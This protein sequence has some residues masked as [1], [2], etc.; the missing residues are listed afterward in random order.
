MLYLTYNTREDGMGAQFQRIVGIIAIAKKFDV[1]YV[2]TPIKQME[3]V[4]GKKYIKKIENYFLIKNHY[5]HVNDRSYDKTFE[6]NDVRVENIEQFK[7]MAEDENINILYKIGLPRKIVDSEPEIHSLVLPEL[8]NIKRT[9]PLIHYKQHDGPNIAIHIRRGDV[10]MAKYP[11]RF[12]PVEFYL[13]LMK[14]MRINMPSPHFH[15]FTEITKENE[16]EFDILNGE[17]VTI[18][19]NLDILETIEHLIMADVLVT[20]KSSFSYLAALYNK[21]MVIYFDFWHS[22]MP[23]WNRIV[24]SNT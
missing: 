2:H 13:E 18:L 16:N 9:L 8:I 23:H 1:V 20:S 17:D 7:K 22:P 6:T 12:I 5:S 19:P 10:N 24:V 21:N 4:S 11:T 14:Q 3:H 15:I